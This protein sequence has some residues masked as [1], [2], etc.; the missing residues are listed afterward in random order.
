MTLNVFHYTGIA[1][2][3]VT[4]TGLPRFK[5][6]INAVDT[7]QTANMNA[8]LIS[9]EASSYA[10]S[11]QCIKI[12]QIAESEVLSISDCPYNFLVNPQ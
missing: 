9:Y 6:I 1:S 3:N 2:K 5:Q 4:I 7:Y 8:E 11:I 12:F 10:S